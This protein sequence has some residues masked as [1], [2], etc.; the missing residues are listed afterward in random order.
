M[1]IEDLIF[2][3]VNKTRCVFLFINL[4]FFLSFKKFYNIY[5]RLLLSFLASIYVNTFTL[6]ILADFYFIF[7]LSFE[8]E[9]D[10]DLVEASEEDILRSVILNY[11]TSLT[12]M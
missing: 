11:T 1:L 8:A 12:F 2:N 3:L 10:T 4:S 5:E 9:D 7:F 6:F